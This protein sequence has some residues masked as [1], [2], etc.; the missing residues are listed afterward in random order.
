MENIQKVSFIGLHQLPLILKLNKSGE[1]VE[2]ITYER[3][4]YY[5]AKDRILWSLGQHEV[6]L[7]GR[8]NARNGEQSRL[9][10]DSIVA[11][12][13]ERSPTKSRNYLSPPLE[14]RYLF[15][16]DKFICAY[17]GHRYGRTN[18]TRDHV[19]PRSRGGKNSWDNVVTACK[20]CNQWKADKILKEADLKLVYVPY[21]P[22]YNE[23]LILKNRNILA[24]QMEFLMKGVSKNSRLH[25]Q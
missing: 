14:N 24:D 10:M 1:A 5:Y 11:V 21:T 9:I 19:T 12:D 2:W 3:S 8:K 23:H 25:L 22:T 17:C 4:A 20:G 7:R 6:I 16:R 15:R 18:L 13:S